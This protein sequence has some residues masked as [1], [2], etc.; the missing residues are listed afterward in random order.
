[1]P[2]LPPSVKLRTAL[3]ARIVERIDEL[4]LSRKEA[5]EAMGLSKQQMSRL[6]ADEDLFTFDR[7]VDAAAGLGLEVRVKTVRP[8]G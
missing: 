4:N 3:R 6:H 8:W 5:G 1:M 2:A 7:L